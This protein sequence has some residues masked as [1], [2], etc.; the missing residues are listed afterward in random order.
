M[1]ARDVDAG[2]RFTAPRAPRS[3]R[4]RGRDTALACVRPRRSKRMPSNQPQPPYCTV[5]SCTVLY[6]PGF[7]WIWLDMA[8]YGAAGRGLARDRGARKHQQ[9]ASSSSRWW[10]SVI[11]RCV[12][13]GTDADAGR[14]VACLRR[15]TVPTIAINFRLYTVP[16][17]LT[18]RAKEVAGDDPT[19]CSFM[20]VVSHHQGPT[21]IQDEWAGA[22]RATG[23]VTLRMR[24]EAPPYSR[25]FEK[26][27]VPRASCPL[28][29][30]PGFPP[31]CTAIRGI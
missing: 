2:K 20:T 16:A 4:E 23:L 13:D 12:R 10:P 30:I 14:P 8:G 3:S 19:R 21:I 24:H 22:A 28:T 17:R 5:S 15:Q 18:R 9:R 7:G 6:W 25:H 29:R 26:R 11:R 31:S 27:C 1:A